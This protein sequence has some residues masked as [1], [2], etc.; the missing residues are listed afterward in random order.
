MSMPFCLHVG[1]P[2]LDLKHVRPGPGDGG[3]A[4]AQQGLAVGRRLGNQPHH[5]REVIEVRAVDEMG[6]D[7]DGGHKDARQI[8]VR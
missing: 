1:E 4:L 3:A 7:I 8:A 6:V 2:V 5:A